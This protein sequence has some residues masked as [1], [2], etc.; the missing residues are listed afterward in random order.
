VAGGG[1]GARGRRG[2]HGSAIIRPRGPRFA[3]LLRPA[4]SWHHARRRPKPG[5]RALP[6]PLIAVACYLIGAVWLGIATYQHR[7]GPDSVRGRGGRIAAVGIAAVGTVIHAAALLEERRLDP[8]AALSLGDTL[9][10]IGLV[11]AITALLMSLRPGKRGMA[12]LL[13]GVAGV[14]EATFSEGA[15]RFSVGQ[16]GWELAFHVAMATTAFAFLTIGMALA[17][18]QVL[19]DRRL[20]AR[21]P[22][23]WLKILTPLE[24]LEHGTFQSILAGFTV[25]TLALVSGAFFVQD[26]F[27][28][29]L[30]HK[31][32]LAIVAWVVFG[33]LL[34]GR[35]RFGWR[36]R[37][38]LRWTFAGYTLL[39]LSY[40]GSKIILENVLGK[41]WG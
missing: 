1:A 27:A 29:H 24:S 4:A 37:Q 2:G 30:V 40:F 18:A 17:L 31:V 9:A 19:V 10:L 3:V 21:Q 23:G 6:L 25:L 26:L 7:S 20:R 36:G 33:V 38:A 12:A 32:T 13:F 15:R 22:L 28:Q 34:L 39:G 5:C 41:H 35:L 16:P 8:Y 11:I 14:L